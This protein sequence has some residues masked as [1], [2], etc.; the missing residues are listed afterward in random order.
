MGTLTSIPSKRIEWI[1]IA[2]GLSIIL[3]V[4]SHAGLSSLPYHL[5]DWLGAFRMPFFFI[6]SGILFAPNKYPTLKS[7]VAKRWPTLVRPFFIFS[8]IVMLGFLIL[9]PTNIFN[10]IKDV[11]L[12]GWGG[13]ALWFIPVM[14]TAQ[15]LFYLVWRL[16]PSNVSM[17]IGL[18]I[19]GF[20][21]YSTYY[22]RIHLPHNL[23]FAFTAGMLYGGGYL[24]RPFLQRKLG[25]ANIISKLIFT[26][27]MGLLSLTFL[28]NSDNPEFAVNNLSSW[29]TYP[30]AL[31]GAMMM[32]GIAMLFSKMSDRFSTSAKQIIIFFGKNSYVVL[33]FHQIILMLLGAT[34]LMPNGIVHRIIM[35][36]LLYGI[37]YLINNYAPFILGRKRVMIS[38]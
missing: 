15:I 21:G 35:W 30:A 36:L 12:N 18:L 19:L 34:K 17:I 26:V 6:V 33:A 23:C 25:N 13:Y 16:S 38:K 20:T 11:T 1:D 27:L 7:F 5:G 32:C 31:G 9:D 4:Y 24:L 37:I 28:L 8:L 29:P 3:V 14:I 2:K 10:K 22:L